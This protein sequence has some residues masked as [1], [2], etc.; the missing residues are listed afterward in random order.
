MP[1]IVIP[2]LSP[3]QADATYVKKSDY[4]AADLNVLGHAVAIVLEHDAD[5]SAVPDGTFIARLPQN[6][7]P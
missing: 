5:A 7:N 2:I 3:E 6:F 4:V 1:Q